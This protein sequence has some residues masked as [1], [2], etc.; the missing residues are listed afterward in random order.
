MESKMSMAPSVGF[1]T[2]SKVK[3]I[4]SPSNTL[5]SSQTALIPATL[6]LLLRALPRISLKKKKKLPC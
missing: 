2:L 3:H 1:H 6:D 4:F 5:S